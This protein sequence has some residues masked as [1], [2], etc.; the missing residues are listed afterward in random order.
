[1]ALELGDVMW[2]VVET[3]A[4]L[5]LTLEDIARMNIAKL[6]RRYPQGFDTE[7]SVNRD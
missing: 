6:E 5:G 2:Y 4:G 1:M 7:R 3:A